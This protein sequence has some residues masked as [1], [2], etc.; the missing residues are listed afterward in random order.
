MD[1][2][3]DGIEV[4][5]VVN[6]EK[7]SVLDALNMKAILEKRG[8]R[9]LGVVL[10]RARG[11]EEE[12]IEEIERALEESVV[13]V[14]PESRIVKEAFDNEECFLEA[15]PGSKPSKEIMWLAEEL[16]KVYGEASKGMSAE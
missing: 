6:P 3:W 14:I 15:E 11:G 10:N 13:A 12:W 2:L 9:I 7:A 16:V 4:L 5:L 8:V 1:V